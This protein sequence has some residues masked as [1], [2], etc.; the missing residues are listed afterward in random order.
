PGCGSPTLF[1][2]WTRF[3]DRCRVCGLDLARS[4]VG[5]GPAAFLTLIVG[6][7]VVALALSLQLAAE[8]PWW[9]HVLLWPPVTV[10]GVLLGL[11]VAKAALLQSEHRNKAGESR[12]RP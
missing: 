4:N 11:R 2:G 1:A 8:P 12:E 5:H 7:L 6:G 9:L 3:A 10:I